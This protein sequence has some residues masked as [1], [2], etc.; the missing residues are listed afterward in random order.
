MTTSTVDYKTRSLLSAM[1]L[2][3]RRSSSLKKEQSK[4]IR[5]KTAMSSIRVQVKASLTTLMSSCL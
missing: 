5:K 3:N 1:T 4:E 2:L